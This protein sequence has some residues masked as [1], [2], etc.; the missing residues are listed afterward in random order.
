MNPSDEITIC[1]TICPNRRW[2][3]YNAISSMLELSPI[4]KNVLLIFNPYDPR[5]HD[6]LLDISE[7]RHADILKF[8]EFRSLSQCWNYSMLMSD[9][10]YVFIL[11]DDIVFKDPDVL[12]KVVQKHKEGYPIVHTTE[13]WSGFSIDKSLIPAL[14]WFDE[15]CSHSWE[16][17]DYRFRMEREEIP[18]Y[19]FDKHPVR[20]LRSQSSR[21]QESRDRSSAYFF[22]KWGIKKFVEDQSGKA[23][24]FSCPK[25][26]KDL[27]Q[28]GFFRNV[29]PLE[30]EPVFYTPNFYPEEMKKYKKMYGSL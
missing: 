6:S 24:D 30:L 13:S 26:R 9:T 7:F 16:D 12:S 22:K 15:N 1:F 3:I 19:R 23:V 18:S 11:N 29:S 2:E 27:Q 25:R 8:S 10:R 4:V 20:H 17:E 14:G 28:T 5:Q 21:R